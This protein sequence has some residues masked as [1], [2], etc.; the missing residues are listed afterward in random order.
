MADDNVVVINDYRG[1]KTQERVRS[2]G[3][4]SVTLSVSYEGDAM[5]VNLDGKAL[6]K[7]GADALIKTLKAQI[8]AI[9]FQASPATIEK[10]VSQAKALAAGRSWAVREFAGGRLGVMTPHASDR[11]FNNSGRLAAGITANWSPM[12]K[13]WIIRF[14]A[15]RFTPAFLSRPGGQAVLARLIDM[16]PA[17]RAPLAQQAVRLAASGAIGDLTTVV[18]YNTAN[19]P[20]EARGR[21]LGAARLMLGLLEAL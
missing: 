2:S 12:Q 3:K 18:K 1:V 8:G 6:A 5:A 21:A 19:P 7:A 16:V 15:N 13:A 14:P 9:G 10:R 20:R 11:L 17:M 4:K